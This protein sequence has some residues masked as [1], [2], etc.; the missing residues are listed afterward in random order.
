MANIPLMSEQDLEEG[1][2]PSYEETQQ[3]QNNYKNNGPFNYGK[4]CDFEDSVA[5]AH[6]SIRLGIISFI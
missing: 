1:D 5:Q 6:V 4:T 3:N 2:L